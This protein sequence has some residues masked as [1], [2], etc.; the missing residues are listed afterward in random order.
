MTDQTRRIP[1]ADTPGISTSS[2]RTGARQPIKS[3]AFGYLTTPFGAWVLRE[4][5]DLVISGH[6]EMIGAALRLASLVKGCEINMLEAEECLVR[7][8]T[9]GGRDA[10]DARRA[11]R[12]ALGKA[13]P[14]SA[15]AQTPIANS[16]E[17]LVWIDRWWAS[18]EEAPPKGRGGGSQRKLLLGF[19]T[20]AR[21]ATKIRFDASYRQ[22]SLQSGIGLSTVSRYVRHPDIAKYVAVTRRGNKRYTTPT[23]FRLKLPSEDSRVDTRLDLTRMSQT[24]TGRRLSNTAIAGLFANGTQLPS[25]HH[26]GLLR[27]DHNHWAVNGG[28]NAL[29]IYKCLSVDEPMTALELA[30]CA[31]VAR[32]TVY[33]QA[34]R[35]VQDGLAEKLDSKWSL[36]AG[37]YVDHLDGIDRLGLRREQYERESLMNREFWKIR[38]AST[39]DIAAEAC[40][41]EL[42]SEGVACDDFDA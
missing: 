4:E 36:V 40:R 2:N 28:G 31:G 26:E 42:V 18:V 38:R 6:Q 12:W 39:A 3:T 15:K 1:G 24:G 5:S 37:A 16:R 19:G 20:I 41:Q 34:E 8:A 13:D 35:L 10:G 33:R 23:E 17:A 14:R 7:S 25:G 30:E 32:S 27:P 29:S 21:R 22:L 9:R 11:F